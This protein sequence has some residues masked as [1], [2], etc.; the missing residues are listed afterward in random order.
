MVLRENWVRTARL[1][2]MR[3]GILGSGLMSGKLGTFFADRKREA[4]R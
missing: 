4:T 1:G 3:I 2:G